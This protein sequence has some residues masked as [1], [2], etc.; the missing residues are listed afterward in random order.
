MK[1]KVNLYQIKKKILKIALN[2][3]LAQYQII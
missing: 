1:F 3:V 2:H